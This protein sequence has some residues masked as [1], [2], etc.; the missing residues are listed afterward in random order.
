M[1]LLRNGSKIHQI[2]SH[3]Q[4]RS[5]LKTKMYKRHEMCYQIETQAISLSSDCYNRA[6]LLQTIAWICEKKHTHVMVFSANWSLW[7]RFS[8]VILLTKRAIT[9]RLYFTPFEIVLA[10]KLCLCGLAGIIFTDSQRHCFW[11]FEKITFF[12]YMVT[13]LGLALVCGAFCEF[14]TFPLVSWVRCGTWLYRFLIFATLLLCCDVIMI[15]RVV[16]FWN[17]HCRITVH[18]DVR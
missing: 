16:F 10:I 11:I 7:N 2:T 14:V 18:F 15:G 1:N 9:C 13:I 8:V 17:L 6:Y 4:E 3:N 5:I 12:D